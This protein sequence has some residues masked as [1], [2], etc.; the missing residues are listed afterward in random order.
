[1]LGGEIRG[2]NFRSSVGYWRES[3][4]QGNGMFLF[5]RDA[6]IWMDVGEVGGGL[7]SF[8]CSRG[9]LLGGKGRGKGGKEES[10]TILA[11]LDPS[12]VLGESRVGGSKRVVMNQRRGDLEIGIRWGGKESGSG[13]GGKR[14]AK[15]ATGILCV[16]QKLNMVGGSA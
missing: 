13:E 16:F 4:K 11:D 5:W 10:V 12:Q 1:M 15:S 3:G 14:L 7:R 6:L 2:E 8:L 9:C